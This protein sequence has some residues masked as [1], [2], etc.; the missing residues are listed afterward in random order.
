MSEQR[1]LNCYTLK[2]YYLNMQ[3]NKTILYFYCLLCTKTII[4][5]MDASNNRNKGFKQ[6]NNL[7]KG[8]VDSKIWGGFAEM[9]NYI[10]WESLTILTKLALLNPVI[11]ANAV[12]EN[13]TRL[14]HF[15][16]SWEK[17]MYVHRYSC[18][19]VC[20]ALNRRM[21]IWEHATKGKISKVFN[22]QHLTSFCEGT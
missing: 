1:I 10:S 17:F 2:V 5:K 18:L 4:T 21:L 11:L 22:Y 15:E 13:W 6:R 20:T 19:K 9:F 12:H 3:L 16:R 8:L 14:A 7:A